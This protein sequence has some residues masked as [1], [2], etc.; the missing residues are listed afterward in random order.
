MSLGRIV[1]ILED[2]NTRYLGTVSH[3]LIPS[4]YRGYQHSVSRHSIT[5]VCIGSPSHYH[6]PSCLYIYIMNRT[7]N[8]GTT[9]LYCTILKSNVL[10]CTIQYITVLWLLYCT[11]LYCTVQGSGHCNVLYCTVLYSTVQYST[12]QWSLYC[13]VREW[14]VIF[15]NNFAYFYQMDTAM[16]YAHHTVL[17]CIVLYCI[18]LYSTLLFCAL[19]Y[20]TL[21]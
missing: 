7:E 9:V 5:A 10:Y 15:H 19:L 17:C 14:S 12:V 3:P 13:T 18:V 11:V 20:C 2:T 4:L 1:P 21:V 16:M 8:F 6:L